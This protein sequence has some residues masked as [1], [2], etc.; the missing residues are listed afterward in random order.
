MMSGCQEL[1]EWPVA[2][3]GVMC[4]ASQATVR[5]W[6]FN[7]LWKCL[8][9]GVG[10]LC[11]TRITKPRQRLKKQRHHFADK[12]PYSQSYGFSSSHIEMWE[13]DYKESWTLKNWCFRT[14]VLKKI[15]LRVRWTARRS[16][17]SILK[18]INSE[19]SLEGLM[20][21]EAEAPVLLPP[22]AKSRLIGKYPDAGKDWRQ[23]EK[24]QQRMR[25][26][27]GIIKSTYMN[28]SK[29]REIVK[30]REAWHTASTGSQ[31]VAE[32]QSRLSGWTTTRITYMGHWKQGRELGG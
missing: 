21:A 15:F 19:Y 9:R 6:A 8:S 27:D 22:D 12:G 23:E 14:V 24:E 7:W 32:G 20:P 5:V 13:L 16:N 26:L 2:A 1:C 17:Q 25:W 31:G 10:D 4:A 30:D 3:G 29:L 28:L 11:F 18:E